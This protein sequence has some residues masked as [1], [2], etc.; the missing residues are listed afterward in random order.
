MNWVSVTLDLLLLIPFIVSGYY[1]WKR[2]SKLASRILTLTLFSGAVGVALKLVFR[3]KRDT[4]FDPFAL[5]SFHATLSWGMFFALPNPW[6]AL[7][8]IFVSGSRVLGGFH[9]LDQ[10]VAG[11]L[12]ALLAWFIYRE[13]EKRLHSL[14]ERKMFHIGV[15]LIAGYISLFLNTNGQILFTG[16]LLAGALAVY[17]LRERGIFRDLYTH[18]SKGERD[19]G[20]VTLTMG[21]FLASFLGLAG[22]TGFI[23]GLVDGLSAIVGKLERAGREERSL[24]GLTGGYIGSF[25]SFLLLLGFYPALFLGISC[26]FAPIIEFF[27]KLDDNVVISLFIIG[28]YIGITAL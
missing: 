16:L 10:V 24:A 15:A 1:W 4:G 25:L 17:A 12:T 14:A 9:T 11:F 6:T 7:Y 21:M 23:L 19:I 26:I 20:P 13:L 22:I 28:F 2:N 3:V 27:S 5:P 8:A 18:Y